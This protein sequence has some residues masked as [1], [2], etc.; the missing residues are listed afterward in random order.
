MA[1]EKDKKYRI[2][3]EYFQ[4]EGKGMVRF[5]PGNFIQSDYKALADRVKDA[6]AIVF[7]GGISPQLEGEEMRVNQPG[8]NGGD[9]TSILLP[10][11]QTKLMQALQATGRPVVFVMMTGSAIAIPWEADNIPAIV[12]AWYGGQSAGTAIADVLFGDYN[13]AG[14]LPVTFYRDDKDLPDFN[15]Y[16]MDNRTYRYFK[17]S[18]LYGFGYGLSYTTFAYDQLKV[19]ATVAKGKTLPV[20]VRVTNTGK[21]DG[22]EVIQLYTTHTDMKTKTPIRALKGFKRIPL[23]AGESRVV[24]FTLTPADLSVVTTEGAL[25]ELPGKVTISIG[26]S[27]PDA[28]TKA[29]KKTVEG[30]VTIK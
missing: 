13:P 8:F 16:T 23:K 15:D 1:T 7:V 10:T 2:V 11:A 28:G 25:K 20:S 5:R 27:Q 29:A 3:F 24:T 21:M 22:E 6:D 17:G 4:G 18:P 12:N 9:R 26:G 14:R 30:N 19:P